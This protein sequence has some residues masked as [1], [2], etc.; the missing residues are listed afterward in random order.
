MV[1]VTVNQERSRHF[2]L[3]NRMD[4]A[5]TK[6]QPLAIAMIVVGILGWTLVQDMSSASDWAILVNV[7]TLPAVGLGLYRLSLHQPW[8]AGVAIVIWVLLDVSMCF[9]GLG[10]MQAASFFT[11]PVAPGCRCARCGC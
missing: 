7:V 9:V 3:L 10:L 4:L 1:D 11:V 2:R 8:W 6:T 5:Q